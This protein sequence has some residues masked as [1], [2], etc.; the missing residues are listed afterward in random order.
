[1]KKT[2]LLIILTV[3]VLFGCAAP[4]KEKIETIFYPPPPQQPRLQFLLS[5][6]DEEDIGKKPSA[7][8]E[9]LLGKMESIKRLAR[10]YDIGAVKGKIYILDRT[11]KKILIIDLVKK[12]FNYIRDEKMGALRDP[13]GIWVT[14]DGYK[15]VSDMQRKQIVVFDNNDNFTRVYGEN[16]QF[17]KPLD[18]AVYQNK[19]YV[20]DFTKHQIIVIDKDSGKTIQV[21]GGI[22]M[23]EGKF[24][25][26]THVIVDKK[27]DVYVNDAFN[28][29][30]QKFDPEGN[31]LKAFGYQGDTLGGF[32]RP[33]GLD[34]DRE[35]HLYVVDTA[36]E[37]VQIFDDKTTDLLLF[38][39]GF[40]RGPGSMYLPNG[41]Y[42]D[43]FNTEYF[44]EYV[45]KDFSVEYLV[46]VGNLLG[47]KKL[48]VYG[49]GKWIGAP[50]SETEEKKVDNTVEQEKA[51]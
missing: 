19:I 28:F 34:I 48:N 32:A 43:Y 15:Y 45:D 14:E 17:D 13:S 41:I 2:L 31:F 22:G 39:G 30:I 16:D 29:R 33:K 51:K 38:F 40:E 9:F 1:M 27:G 46:Y 47:F 24:F 21:I 5:I 8:A 10:P 4:E 49:F 26:P 12:E 20:C 3:M 11:Y 23:K 37:N 42:I 18:V 36:F 44:K 25:K 35:G 50:L 6:T 7:L